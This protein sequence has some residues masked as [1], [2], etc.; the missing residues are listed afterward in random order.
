MTTV[1]EMMVRLFKPPRILIVQDASTPVEQLLHRDYECSVDT[2]DG[3][4]AA[5]RFLQDRRYDLVLIDIGLLNGTS[6]KVIQASQRFCPGTPVVVLKIAEVD[7][8]EIVSGDGPL[9]VL[10]KPLTSDLLQTLFRVF[11][12]KARTREI[13]NYCAQAQTVMQAQVNA[14]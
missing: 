4:D 5:I 2:T 12:I 9:T 6:R 13:A 7:L 1:D 3:G 8:I 14:S 10:A 11:K